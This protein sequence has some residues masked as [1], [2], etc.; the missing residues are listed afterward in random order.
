M[1]DL[2]SAG[3]TYE[4]ALLAGY[5]HLGDEHGRRSRELALAFGAPV[6]WEHPEASPGRTISVAIDLGIPCVYT[7][8]LGGGGA[9]ES[10]VRCYTEGVRRVMAALGMADGD[11]TPRHRQFWRGSGDTDAAVA[12]S[13][14]GLFYNRVRIGEAV[15]AGSLLGEIIDF[16]GTVLESFTAPASRIVALIRRTPRVAP[17]DGLYLLTSS[18]DETA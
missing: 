16:D 13:H 14:A 11:T 7:E 15:E 3:T 1:I 18:V 5:P 2:H 8:S 17:G 12:A 10:V 6:L 4:M 9:P